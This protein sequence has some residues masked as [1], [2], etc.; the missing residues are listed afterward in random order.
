MLNLEKIINEYVE[1][2]AKENERSGEISI[3]GI[4]SCLRKLILQERGFAKEKGYIPMRVQ[5]LRVF[6][7]G[8]IFE[9]KAVE[10]IS[11]C[12]VKKQIPTSYRGIKGTA[13]VICRNDDGV[14]ELVDIKTVNSKKFDYLKDLPD[15]GYIYQLTAYWLGLKDEYKLSPICHVLYLEK[16]SVLPKQMAFRPE[17]YISMVNKRIDEI[18]KARKDTELPE[19]L[20]PG[21][22]GRQPWMCFSCGK[23]NGVRLW[24]N[25]IAFCPFA[26]AKYETALKTASEPKVK[27]VKAVK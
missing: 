1:K 6:Q 11:K 27:K 3:S 7:A 14:N 16:D 24:C 5:Q 20:V 10:W 12:I 19:E 21:E 13:D 26:L 22:D 18:E 4:G 15:E 17:N 8:Y 9:E 25:F 2:K 23:A